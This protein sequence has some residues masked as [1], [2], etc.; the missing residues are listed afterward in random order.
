M[1]VTRKF[2]N[3]E[4]TVDVTKEEIIAYL[5]NLPLKERTEL[6]RGLFDKDKSKLISNIKDEFEAL[7][8]IIGF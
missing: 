8:V 1:K 5:S 4:F 6:V 2:N 3:I 7:R